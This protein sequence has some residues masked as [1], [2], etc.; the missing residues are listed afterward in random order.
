MPQRSNAE[1]D[2]SL[3]PLDGDALADDLW[4]PGRQLWLKFRTE[5]LGHGSDRYTPVRLASHVALILVAVGLLM[6]SRV[7]LPKWEVAPREFLPAPPATPEPVTLGQLVASRGGGNVSILEPLTRNAVPF[8]I[9]PERPRLDVETYVVQPG[10]TVFGI[11]QKFGLKPDTLLWSNPTLEANPDLLRIGD[12][13]AILPVNG[14]YHKIA[15]KETVET[16]AKKYK[17]A[18]DVIVGYAWNKL[19][20]NQP[21]QTGAYLIVP[22][23]QKPY[24][25][26]QVAIY[27]GPMPKGAR[28]GTGRFVWP[29]GG[30]ITQ[31]YW[32]GHRALDI[33][34]WIGNPVVAADSGFVVYAGWDK[35]GYGNLIVVDHGNGFSTYYAH[36]SKILVRPG[37]SVA[38]GQRV[39]SVGSTG[40]S[41]GPHLHFEVRQRGVQRNPFGYLR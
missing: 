38:Q 20:T 2:A 33:A 12:K 1:A 41:T 19:A 14:V 15:T 9:V 8:T 22:G 29:A 31:N 17:V 26:R 39:G 35:T 10:D 4:E 16:I 40:H 36:L 5:L 27:N 13:V 11:A 7:N 28:H 18:P 34:S 23:G 25:P 37:E 30:S 6:L 3:P 32:N 21:L 24:V